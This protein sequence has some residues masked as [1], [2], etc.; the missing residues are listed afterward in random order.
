MVAIVGRAY[1]R[2]GKEARAAVPPECRPYSEESLKVLC[3]MLLA[4]ASKLG[5][6]ENKWMIR[7]CYW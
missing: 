4:E 2:E 1:A 3:E 5:S 6:S 7:V